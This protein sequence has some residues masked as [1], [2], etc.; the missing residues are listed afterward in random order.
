LVSMYIGFNLAAYWGEDIEPLD[1]WDENGQRIDQ[2]PHPLFGD[3]RVRRAIQMGINVPVLLNAASSG[4]GTVLPAITLPVS[5][6]YNPDLTPIPY[7]PV[8]AEQLL[9][10]AGWYWEAGRGA[11][12]CIDCLYAEEGAALEFSLY[13]YPSSARYSITADLI[14]QQ[15]ALIGV[16][17]H[18]AESPFSRFLSQEYDAVLSGW[19]SPYPNNPDISN[20]FTSQADVVDEGY[21]FGSYYNP[22][23]DRL[24]T[25][26]LNQPNCEV[27][28]RAALYR[29]AEAILQ[30]D[31][32][33]AWLYA[34]SEMIVAQGNV[35][36][37]APYPNAPLWN[38]TDW[39]VW[40][41]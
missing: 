38:I 27:A 35:Q 20:L 15:L 18:P 25:E 14:Q 1:G 16:S 23:V 4:E 37:F 19:Y 31:Q 3:V 30:A 6:A 26:A 36:N 10:E 11:R 40:G 12:V 29:Q 32:P 7:D 22:E 33:Y 24:L 21:N 39:V 17:A 8:A 9:D 41:E 5:W 28:A 2:P 34:P 13:Y